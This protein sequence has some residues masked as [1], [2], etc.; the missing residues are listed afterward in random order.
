LNPPGPGLLAQEASDDVICE[1]LSGSSGDSASLWSL[2]WS[3]LACVGA[4]DPDKQLMNNLRD[5]KT[6]VTGDVLNAACQIVSSSLLERS[7]R[8][9][10][11]ILKKLEASRLR[12][13]LKTVMQIGANLSQSREY[14][15]F[16]EDVLTKVVE[17]LEEFGLS[18]AEMVVFLSSCSTLV[19]AIPSLHRI[20]NLTTSSGKRE[21]LDLKRDWSRFLLCCR[22]VVEELFSTRP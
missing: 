8:G 7:P 19:K 11:A 17:P 21:R 18:L 12:S 1:A 14:R 5:I 9:G 22:F 3:V 15:D 6:V 20:S 4:M 16:F 2:V 13:A 10:P